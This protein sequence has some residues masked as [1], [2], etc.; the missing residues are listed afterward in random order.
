MWSLRAGW[1]CFTGRIQPAGRRLEAPNLKRVNSSMKW[2][3]SSTW[4]NISCFGKFLKLTVERRIGDFNTETLKANFTS[5]LQ[6][7]NFI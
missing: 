5:R 1:K 3:I 7:V 6:S 2:I 4:H